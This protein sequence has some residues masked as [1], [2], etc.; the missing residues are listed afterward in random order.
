M[1]SGWRKVQSNN[2]ILF[3]HIYYK[4]TRYLPLYVYASLYFFLCV[5]IFI[6]KFIFIIRSI[7]IYMNPVLLQMYIDI[8]FAF[9]VQINLQIFSILTNFYLTHGVGPRNIDDKQ[10][11]INYFLVNEGGSQIFG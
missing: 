7:H 10:A 6:L 3:C 5:Y 11:S 8:V 9:I 2:L 4:N 1:F